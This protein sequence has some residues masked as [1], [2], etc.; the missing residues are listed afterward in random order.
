MGTLELP[1]EKALKDALKTL[2]NTVLPRLNAL[3]LT[4][5]F[6]QLRRFFFRTVRVRGVVLTVEGHPKTLPFYPEGVVADIPETAWVDPCGSLKLMAEP[7]ES[8]SAFDRLVAGVA[9]DWNILNAARACI[10]AERAYVRELRQRRKA[11]K[12]YLSFD[13]YPKD[14]ERCL[15]GL[16]LTTYRKSRLETNMV[17]FL[18]HLRD[19]STVEVSQWPKNRSM[20]ECGQ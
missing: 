2:G 7:F 20:L 19:T 11:F 16:L 5:E 15:S 10:E 14:V 17:D 6:L 13:P 4:K 8:D 1:E 3:T 18:R 12:E 9:L